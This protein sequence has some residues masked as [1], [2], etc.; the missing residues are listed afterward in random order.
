MHN[1]IETMDHRQIFGLF[2]DLIFL[3]F[4]SHFFG[5][6]EY[7]FEHDKTGDFLH[8]LAWFLSNRSKETF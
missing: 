1:A 4:L 2:V 7:Y 5:F 8:S 3:G 6:M